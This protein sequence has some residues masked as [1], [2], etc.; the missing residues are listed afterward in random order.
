MR[1]KENSS[2]TSSYANKGFF[3]GIGLYSLFK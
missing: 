2:L 3:T 1:Y